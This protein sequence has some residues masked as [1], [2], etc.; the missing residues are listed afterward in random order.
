MK[1]QKLFDILSPLAKKEN[2]EFDFFLQESESLSISF[3][4]GKLSHHSFSKDRNFSL[5]LIKD[6][7]AGSSYT[8][9]LLPDKIK[10][11]FKKAFLSW[12]VSEKQEAGELPS[13]STFQSLKNHTIK[14]DIS[15]EE[16][17]SLAESMDKAASKTGKNI[18][19]LL[20]KIAELKNQITFGNSKNTGGHF[21]ND[22]IV[23]ISH[24]LAKGEKNMGQG[25]AFQAS[26]NYQDMKETLGRMS[27]KKALQKA[28]SVAPKTGLYPVLF[29]GELAP[30][31]LLGLLLQHFDGKRIYEKLSLLQ[32]TLGEKKFSHHLTITDDPFSPWGL[33]LRPFDGEGY[34]C[35]KKPLVNKGVIQNYLTNSFLAK[36]LKLPH[37]AHA[38]RMPDGRI[39]VEAT[40]T[41]ILPGSV[42]VE[43]IR[44]RFKKL[45]ELDYLKGLAGYNPISG[46]FSIESEGFLWTEGERHPI[47]QFTVSGNIIRLFAELSQITKE[48]YMGLN[49]LKAPALLVP[50]LS[51]A[52]K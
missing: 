2:L 7:K 23:A 47:S 3:Q 48:S 10:E 33:K 13:K 14:K 19:S 8:K 5:R 16:K 43:K 50:S 51:I 44:S 38:W 46:D 32:N 25:L 30:P 12:K 28:N 17:A 31:V 45:I 15:F 20:N 6:G 35:C 24:S 36:K 4:N 26:K 27:A 9:D 11:V 29:T 37:T 52:G 40:N 39:A 18:Q 49:G 21:S 1:Q 22:Y 34:P 42:A 41:E